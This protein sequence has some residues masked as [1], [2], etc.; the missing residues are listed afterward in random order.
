M[1]LSDNRRYLVD[2][3]G[4]PFFYL[5]DTAW[6]LFYMLDRKETEEYL[7]NRREKGFTVIMACLLMESCGRGFENVRNRFGEAPLI[8]LDPTKPNE[9]FF[10]YVDDVIEMGAELGLHF[11]LLPTW[12]EYV[13]PVKWGKG[14]ILFHTKNAEIYGEFLGRRYKEKEVV[15]VLGGDRN[16][17]E[18]SFLNVWRAM[19]KGLRRGDGGKNPITYHPA[20][21]TIGQRDIF[22]SG[23]WIHEEPWL[24]FNMMQ[25]STRWDLNNYDYILK[26][27]NRI[28]V[29]PVLEGETRY[30]NSHEYFYI[31]PPYGRRITPHQVR[32]AAYNAMLSG[33]MGHTYGCRDV[34]TF[35]QPEKGRLL[36]DTGIHWK[37]AMDLPGAFQMGCL[38]KLFTDYPWYKLVPDQEKKI[39]K[40]GCG[41]NATYTPAAISIDQ[42]FALVYVP[43]NQPIYVDG[44]ALSEDWVSAAWFNPR[45]GAYGE[46]HRYPVSELIE[47]RPPEDDKD[48]D[49][50]LLLC[51]E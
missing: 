12:G 51:R 27:Y 24:D 7:R 3:N 1:R 23:E 43:E 8:H 14:P 29:K 33:A 31:N 47:L 36:R 17:E 46:F 15:W 5:A 6:F 2:D 35:Y 50:V 4:T 39:V 38:R 10:E 40:H 37:E 41:T 42:D 45:S 48:P 11:A 19:A 22:S 25:T 49:Y 20:P 9:R 21:C 44:S 28:P 26:D 34:F 18:E 13:G 32:K 30:E 16:P